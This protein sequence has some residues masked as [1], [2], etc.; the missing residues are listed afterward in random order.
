MNLVNATVTAV[1]SADQLVDSCL[2][3]KSFLCSIS[4]LEST[5]PFST[6]A[7]WMNPHKK[8]GAQ[9]WNRRGLNDSESSPIYVVMMTIALCQ[10]FTLAHTGHTHTYTHT[11]HFSC[12]PSVSCDTQQDK[13]ALV[14][15]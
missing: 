8:F 11:H 3:S 13:V 15:K 7:H 4:S 2:V 12:S 5:L 14:E 1:F 9:I 10:L 6:S